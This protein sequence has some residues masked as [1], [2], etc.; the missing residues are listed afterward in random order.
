MSAP[1]V[2]TEGNPDMTPQPN[3][4]EYDPGCVK[5]RALADGDDGAEKFF[6]AIVPRGAGFSLRIR[7][8][9]LE[10]LCSP[11]F[12]HARLFTRP[13]P[14]ADLGEACVCASPIAL[15]KII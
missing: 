2:A 8:C 7:K 9:K 13:G 6:A 10:E 5:S 14:V 1:T 11:H 15:G 4:V 3:S 12:T